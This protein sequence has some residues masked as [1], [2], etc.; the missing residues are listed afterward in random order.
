MGDHDRGQAELAVQLAKIVAQRIAGE[1][2]ERAERLVHQHDARLCGERARHA[3]ALA[4]AAGEF[5][6]Q[7]V[8]VLRAVEPHQVEQF[9]HPRGNLGGRRA[10]QLRRD[11]DIAGDAEM[12]KQPAALEDIADPPA[13]RNRIDISH[14]LAFD[15][16]R[17]AVGLDQ[18]VGEPQQRG[19]A[20]A[21]AADDGQKLALGDLERDV[22]DGHHAAAIERLAD[23]RIG[24]QW[25]GRHSVRSQPLAIPNGYSDSR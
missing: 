1:G 17:A 2:I 25:R 12:R 8:A 23:M 14:V 20:R 4:L 13:Q 6:R 19:L 21:G 11:A 7:A 5:M 15:R 9:V 18:P 3:D 24:D 10:Q 22:V 16:D